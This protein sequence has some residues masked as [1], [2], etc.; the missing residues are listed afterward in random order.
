LRLRTCISDLAQNLYLFELIV[1]IG[2][3]L[4]V[5]RLAAGGGFKIALGLESPH[6]SPFPARFGG[7][8]CLS[9]GA[10]NY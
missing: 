1:G 8:G 9:F 4:Y 10:E 7:C 5:F 3:T 6:R 2:V